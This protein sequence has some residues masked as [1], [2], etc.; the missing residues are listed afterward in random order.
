[1][2]VREESGLKVLLFILPIVLLD[3]IREE[4]FILLV[5]Y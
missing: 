3:T 4:G 2:R 1:M 5:G